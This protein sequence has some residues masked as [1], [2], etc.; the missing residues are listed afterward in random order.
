MA[1]AL[2]RQA[3]VIGVEHLADGLGGYLLLDGTPVVPAIE[4]LE[5]EN[6]TGLGT[7]ESEQIDSGH[8][9]PRNRGIVSHAL[10]HLRWQPESSV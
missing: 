6:L 9:I 2:S 8:A 10:D 3:L 4:G 5:V 7:P 1:Q